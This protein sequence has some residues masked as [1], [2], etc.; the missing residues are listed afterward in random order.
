MA[1]SLQ[2]IYKINYYSTLRHVTERGLT[3]EWVEASELTGIF[4][5]AIRSQG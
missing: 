2:T 3:S 4:T 5:V 1:A